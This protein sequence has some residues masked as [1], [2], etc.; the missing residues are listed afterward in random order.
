VAVVREVLWLAGGYAAD[1]AGSMFFTTSQPPEPVGP[2]QSRS[3][4]QVVPSALQGHS[5]AQPPER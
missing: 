4:R 2:A 5:H 1:L 3:P